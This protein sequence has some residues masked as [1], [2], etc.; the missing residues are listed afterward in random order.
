MALFGCSVGLAPERVFAAS[1]A[2]R[3][4]LT[5]DGVWN[6]ATD[7]DNRGETEKWFLPET[8][9]PAMPLPGYAPTADG[10][11][12]VPGI[13]DNQGYGTETDKVR[14]NF[15]G[16][17]WY[18][19]TVEVPEAWK[20]KRIFLL[21]TG[22]SRYSKIWVNGQYAGEHIGYLSVQ[23]HE[24]SRQAV[25]GRAVT[26]AIQ[27]DSKQRWEVDTVF[28][29]SSLADYMDV[30]WGGIWGHVLLEARSDAWLS[31]L[32]VQPDVPGSR[33][34]ACATLNGS[35][36]Q[37]DGARLEV[38]DQGGRRVAEAVAKLDAAPAAGQTVSATVALPGA[39]L[40]TP[41]TP[42]L[43]K[44]RLT[45]L[46]GAQILDTV[47][48]R[49]GMR[50]FSV[51]GY[52]LLLNGKRVMLLGYGDD[53]IYPEQ[54]AMP[55]D[56]ELHLRQLR[57]IKSYGFNHVRHH[58]TVMPP[59]YYEACDEVGIITTVEFPIVYAPYIPG[60]GARWKKEVPPGTDPKPALD[61]YHREWAAVITRNRNHP[62]VLCWVMGNELYADLPIRYSFRDIAQKLDPTGLYLDS[63]GVAMNLLSDPKRDR[64][65]VAIYDIQFAEWDD[66]VVNKNKFNTPKPVKPVL[67]HEAGNY[68]TFSRP[69]L[70]DLF[71]HNIKPF[72]MSTSQ[73]K[74]EKLG[75]LKEAM[76]WAEKSERLYA[77]LHKC[78]LEWLRKNPYLSGYHW[79]LFQ[80][81]W[82]SA[83][84]IVDHYFRPK[85]ITAEEVRAYNSEVVLLQD[86]LDQTYRAKSRLELKLLVSNFSPDVLGGTLSWEVKAGARTVAANKVALDRIPQGD[87]VGA[88]QIAVELPETDVP[89]ALL[90]TASLAAGG[91]L[92]RNEWPARLYPALIR[93]S[94]SPV[95]VFADV[96]QSKVFGAWGAAPIP[97]EGTLDGRAVYVTDTFFDPR[98]AA[99]MERGA[100]VVCLGGA[101]P[102]LNAYP[103][104]FRTTWWKAGDTPE[105]NNTGTFVYDHPATRAIA[106]D[107]WCDGGWFHLV[108]GAKKYVLEG[109]PARPDVIVRGLPSMAMVQDEALL[110][111]VG[112]GKGS[113]IVSGLNHGKAD[114]RP[115]N[116]W[117]LARII[118]YAATLP[119]PKA[120]WPASF[121]SFTFAAPEGC[122]PGFRCLAAG[123][124]I[125][126][127]EKSSWYSYRADAAPVFICRQDRVGN[128]V[129][130]ETVPY[131][132]KAQ[133]DERVTFVF[134]GGL[135]FSSEPQTEGFVLDVNGKEALRF[136]MPAA[137]RWKSAD[138]RVEL[139]FESRRTLSVDQFGLFHVTVSRDLL[140]PGQTCR[141][142]V[143]S[144]GAGSRR[145]FG[146]NPY[147]DV[148]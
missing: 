20:G 11:I 96:P 94:A 72:W 85:S 114:G 35:A 89:S 123:K 75:L 9:L 132:P 82:T 119:H 19:R 86:G 93:P 109:A 57:L 59:E 138:G 37:S 65:T 98:L 91:K 60:T 143:R 23:E 144:L 66:P 38:F 80:D 140:T 50:Q 52:S 101:D 130:W 81:Y 29:A 46:K 21:V 69:D 7:P 87:V 76:H 106:P 124:G 139:R 127:P 10:T 79:W 108:E 67:S 63:D 97:A 111:A 51:S 99:A 117:L 13:W 22:V 83:N 107:G 15:V 28:G 43:Y 95:P 137:E 147:T 47:E 27:V 121:V 1:P 116:E 8:K 49:F 113:L 61:T 12:R 118:D 88:A 34:S 122:L 68:V 133:P 71:R 14:H 17:G 55:S 74:L 45:L 25:P 58:S 134:A 73:A 39:S 105:K 131:I 33:C 64:P 100:C 136:D 36:G 18:R 125:A 53:H 102:F 90:V 3:S 110:F 42:T 120:V 48:S 92:Y 24:I 26:V 32:F 40:W 56:K 54:M 16:K 5:L 126:A 148:R 145:W 115:E 78:N 84:G 4:V 129:V 142:G 146:L 62:S 30:A 70:V 141:L 135:G 2:A 31:D 41:E 128:A 77:Y 112:V 6:F 103:V 104:T 44:A